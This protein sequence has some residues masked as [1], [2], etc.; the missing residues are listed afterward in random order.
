MRRGPPGT[1]PDWT[2]RLQPA[3]DRLRQVHK[4]RDWQ[5]YPYPFVF[6]QFD[7]TLFPAADWREASQLAMRKMA[8]RDWAGDRIDSDDPALVKQIQAR[9]LTRRGI[10]AAD[11]EILVTLGSQQAMFLISTLIRTQARCVGLE[12]PGY[13]DLDKPVPFVRHTHARAGAGAGRTAHRRA[14]GRLRLRVR[15]PQPPEPDRRHHATGGPGARCWRP[16]AGTTSW[17]WRTTTTA[18]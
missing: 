10:W 7:P 6:G 15:G 8:V 1:A 3:I 11:D 2:L 5:R 14:T 17:W 12:E 16:R 4:P 9:V 18:N 13:P